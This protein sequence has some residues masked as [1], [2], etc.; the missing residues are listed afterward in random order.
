MTNRR[1]HAQT[2]THEVP[3]LDSMEDPVT[4]VLTVFADIPVAV[5][6]VIFVCPPFLPANQY[7]CQ[8]KLSA[9]GDRSTVCQT[10][11]VQK[12]TVSAQKAPAAKILPAS[13]D[14]Q[15]RSKNKK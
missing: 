5:A 4:I 10:P 8:I 7:C 9:D 12:K 3:N 2:H 1:I 13:A 14:E 15:D 6:V 11:S